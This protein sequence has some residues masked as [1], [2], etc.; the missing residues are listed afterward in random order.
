MFAFY[1]SCGK[2]VLSPVEI[3]NQ[4]PGDEHWVLCPDCQQVKHRL[5][6]LVLS[7][8]HIPT[9]WQR[10]L[11]VRDATDEEI[12]N[13]KIEVEGAPGKTMHVLRSEPSLVVYGDRILRLQPSVPAHRINP[14]PYK[15]RRWGVRI[16]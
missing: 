4:Y 13:T 5:D 9:A 3:R 15:V 14:F 2:T 11:E 7:E 10:L 16:S 1:L 6:S 8:Q 12:A